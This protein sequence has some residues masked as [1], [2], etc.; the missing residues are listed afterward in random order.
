MSGYR[1][2]V[3]ALV[4]SVVA[5]AL[6]AL[7]EPPVTRAEWLGLLSAAAVALGVYQTPNT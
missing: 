6:V 2:S 4:G 7:A 5:W 3:V 1:K